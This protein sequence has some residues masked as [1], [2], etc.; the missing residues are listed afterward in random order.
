MWGVIFNE[1]ELLLQLLDLGP[2][3][4]RHVIVAD[5]E[6]EEPRYKRGTRAMYTS[7]PVA[8]FFAQMEGSQNLHG[9]NSTQFPE[10]RCYLQPQT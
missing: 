9:R 8:G 3:H 2:G 10:S 6:T 7:R 1:R 5:L 4:D